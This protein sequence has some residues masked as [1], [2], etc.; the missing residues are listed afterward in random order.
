MRKI[1]AAENEEQKA[2]YIIIAVFYYYLI[3]GEKAI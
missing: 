1:P 2:N 3:K